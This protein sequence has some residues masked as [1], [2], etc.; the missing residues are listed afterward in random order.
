MSKIRINRRKEYREALRTYIR[1]TRGLITKLD[2]QFDKYR[3]YAI[4][5]FKKNN[6]ISDKYYEDFWQSFYK[7]LERN[8]RTVIQESSRFIKTTRLL[9]QVDDQVSTVTYD[10]VT[11]HTAQN[12]TYITETTRKK[13]QSAIAYSISEGLGQDD[14]AEVIGKSTAFSSTRSKVIARTETHQAYN[15]GNNKIAGTLALKK[16]VKEWLSALD[17]RTRSWHADMSGTKVLYE[18]DFKVLTPTKAGLVE[19]VMKYTGDDQGLAENVINCRCFTM[20]YDE[21]DVIVE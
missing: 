19:D 4:R 14:T 1:L 9:K 13:I 15:Y 10:Y 5:E 12:V 20:Y 16:P 18:D 8:A 3:K 2:K 6:A 7:V 11:T 21:E 17:T